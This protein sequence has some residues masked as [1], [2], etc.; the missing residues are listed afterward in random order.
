SRYEF[1]VRRVL[2]ISSAPTVDFKRRRKKPMSAT[3]SVDAQYLYG[4]DFLWLEITGKC[5]LACTHCYADS[6]PMKPLSEG[7]TYSDWLKIISEAYEL[8]CRQIQFIGG[9]PT[10]HPDIC[11]LISYAK[12]TGFDF[13]EVFTNATRLS[14]EL[15]QC[16]VE[17]NVNVAASFY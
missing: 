16:F 9:E 2:V 1:F 15:I 12:E 17:N 11:S 13:I 7:L 10:L 3:N 4:L 6:S 8:G 5:N 14:R